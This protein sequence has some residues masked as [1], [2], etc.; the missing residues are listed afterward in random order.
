MLCVSFTV[1]LIAQCIDINIIHNLQMS[2]N[3][4]KQESWLENE[5]W[6][7]LGAYK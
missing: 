7:Y 3:C 1:S 4:L 5:V 2:D 6:A